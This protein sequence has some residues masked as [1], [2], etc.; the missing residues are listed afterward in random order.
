M[1]GRNDEIELRELNED[2]DNRFV[3]H[4]QRASFV[5]HFE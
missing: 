1:I 5:F 2:E 3:I 4:P